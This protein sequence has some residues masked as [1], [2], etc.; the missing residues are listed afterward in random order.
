MPD[1]Q[2]YFNSQSENQHPFDKIKHRAESTM[3]EEAPM[4]EA[5]EAALY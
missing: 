4:D 3:P 1:S 2:S 5:Q